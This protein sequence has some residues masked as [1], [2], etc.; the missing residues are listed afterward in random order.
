MVGLG[1]ALIFDT[2]SYFYGMLPV[3]M[4]IGENF[5][6]SAESVTAAMLICRNCATF[7]SPM[8]PAPLLGV[9]LAEVDIREHIKSSFGY[10]WLLSILCLCFAVLINII[11]L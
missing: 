7:I 4:G 6:V 3:M 8:V 10:T 5:G 11:T 1:L 2:N 9:G